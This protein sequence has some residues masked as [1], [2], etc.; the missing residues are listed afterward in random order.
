MLTNV[1]R[2]IIKLRLE[3][4]TTVMPRAMDRNLILKSA[5]F[6]PALGNKFSDESWRSVGVY[7]SKHDT[8]IKNFFFFKSL[9][10][11]LDKHFSFKV[12]GMS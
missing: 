5:L 12:N 1:I 7:I 4:S 6:E 10:L 2:F 3:K 8:V 9:F 11:L